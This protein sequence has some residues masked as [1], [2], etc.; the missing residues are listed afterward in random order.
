MTSSMTGSGP[1][2]FG[3]PVRYG[4]HNVDRS[5]GKALDVFARYAVNEHPNTLATKDVSGIV[6]EGRQEEDYQT[7]TP[8]ATQPPDLASAALPPPPPA[9]FKRRVPPS[10]P[11]TQV[12]PTAH[13][14]LTH[15]SQNGRVRTGT[16]PTDKCTATNPSRAAHTLKT[17]ALI[18]ADT[19]GRT[20]PR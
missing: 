20:F 12:S 1:T 13:R 3:R 9:A 19:L 8:N 15:Q 5:G 6:Q 4:S 2:A 14:A 16:L 10:M 11:T 18:R 7:P 17:R